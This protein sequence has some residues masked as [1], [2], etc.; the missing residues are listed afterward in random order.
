MKT[1]IKALVLNPKGFFI[2]AS[3]P[4]KVFFLVDAQPD[5]LTSKIIRAVGLAFLFLLLFFHEKAQSSQ[6]VYR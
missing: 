2:L 1:L 5:I 3:Q 4:E 6:I